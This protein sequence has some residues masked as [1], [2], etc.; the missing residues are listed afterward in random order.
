[1]QY[2]VC[3]LCR[4]TINPRSPAVHGRRLPVS[5]FASAAGRAPNSVDS[6]YR[7]IRNRGD[8]AKPHLCLQSFRPSRDDLNWVGFNPHHPEEHP[9]PG[10]VVSIRAGLDVSVATLAVIGRCSQHRL[11]RIAA[12]FVQDHTI[13]RNRSL[14]KTCHDLSL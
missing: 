4:F 1:M 12:D 13:D 14:Q 10:L 6:C 5:N 11:M 7:V 3:S 2:A 9:D 8:F